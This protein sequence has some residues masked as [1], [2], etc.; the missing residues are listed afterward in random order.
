VTAVPFTDRQRAALER[1]IG[2]T[3]AGA[4]WLRKVSPTMD[5]A[6]SHDITL[7]AL[8]RACR[9]HDDPPLKFYFH[10]LRLE[11]IDWY[12]S[13]R[14]E[15]GTTRSGRTT[16][17][18]VSLSYWCHVDD[19]WEEWSAMFRAEDPPT[20]D[21]RDEIERALARIPARQRR[22][23]VGQHYHGY[24][25]AEIAAQLGVS[26]ATIYNDH[27]EAIARLR[28][29]PIPSRNSRSRHRHNAVA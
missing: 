29:E 22:V 26:E 27:R 10:C 19:A 1:H 9:R 13:A 4:V 25:R 8:I 24:T 7:A 23:L 15:G 17:A 2:Y 21:D 16:P 5:D 28:G 12:R 14:N 18:R 11:L 3:R 6:D 20:V